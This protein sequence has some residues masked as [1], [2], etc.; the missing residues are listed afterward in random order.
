MGKKR[1]GRIVVILNVSVGGR[2]EAGGGV[3]RRCL[4]SSR[5]LAMFGKLK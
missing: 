5:K 4:V 1:W 2:G 3:Y